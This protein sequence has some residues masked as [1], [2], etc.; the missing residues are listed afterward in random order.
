MNID[1]LIL[2]FK[3]DELKEARIIKENG[4][5]RGEIKLSDPTRNLNKEDLENV[6]KKVITE[7]NL[8]SEHFRK[9]INLWWGEKWI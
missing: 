7:I 2:K 1:E 3:D 5:Y 8:F 6:L 4:R 9:T